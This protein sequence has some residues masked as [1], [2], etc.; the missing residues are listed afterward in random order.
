M[1]KIFLP[2][3][4][5]KKSGSGLGLAV[6]KQGVEQS[7]GSIEVESE[8]NKGTKFTIRFDVA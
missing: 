8:V 5:T 7:G 6:V 3:F 1:D 4:T 2:S